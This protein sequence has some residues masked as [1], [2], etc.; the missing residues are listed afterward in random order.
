MVSLA[1]FATAACAKPE[2]VQMGQVMR[3]GQFVLRADSVDVYSR[4]HQGVPLEVKVFFT[5]GGGNR[6]D[7]LEFAE[8]VSR[9]GR[10]FLVTSAGWRNRCW[11][12]GIGEDQRRAYV[13]GNPP[14]DS[15]GYSLEIGN[16]YDEPKRFILDLGK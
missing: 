13:V 1:G 16:P 7:R 9:K 12:S 5:V 11:L 4:A 6:F 14:L 8:T 10:V 2:P 15:R 3:M